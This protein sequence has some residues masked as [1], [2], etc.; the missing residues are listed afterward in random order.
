MTA[1]GTALRTARQLGPASLL[2][3]SLYQI[4]L[5]S[6]WIRRQTPRGRWQDLPAPRQPVPPRLIWSADPPAQA[7]WQE[8]AQAEAI[9]RAD[10]IL[11][12]R[13]R[14]FGLTA[15]ELGF[16][17]D[18]AAFVPL[19]GADS[20]ERVA[21]G[22]HW[23]EY[24]LDQLGA[25]AKLLWEPARFGW[26]WD[27]ARAY[28][29]RPD[30]RFAQ[31][32]WDLFDSWCQANQPNTGP[33]WIS[34]Q[35]AAF[36][37]LALAYAR[38]AFAGWLTPDRLG[39]I[40]RVMAGHASRI[41]PTLAYARAQANN[42]LLTEAAAMETAGWLLPWHRRAA[43][44]RRQGRRWFVAG[45][46]DQVFDDGGYI[47]HSTNYQRLA[48]ELGLWLAQL[49]ASQGAPLPDA[50]LIALRR[51]TRLLGRLADPD[52]GQIPNFGP[53]DGAQLLA[54]SSCGFEDYRPAL[55]AAA[56]ILGGLPR[57]PAGPWDEQAH[58]LAG[59][60]A[61][62]SDSPADY[63]GQRSFPLAGLYLLE[64]GAG[65]A[66][67]RAAR[68][69]GRPGH[70]D[71]LQLD[72]WHGGRNLLVDGGTYLYAGGPPWDNALAG[73]AAHNGPMVGGQEP[74]RRAGRFLWLPRGHARLQMKRQSPDDRLEVVTAEHTGYGWLGVR[75]RRTVLRVG[76]SLWLVI[77]DLHGAGQHG[78]TL[79]W[80]LP[81]GE[82][83]LD[84][85]LHWAEGDDRVRLWM[86]APAGAQ[87]LYVAGERVGGEALAWE[88]PVWGWQAPNYGRLA[89][90]THFVY[91]G[92]VTLPAQLRSWWAIGGQTWQETLID[93]QPGPA[94]LPQLTTVAAAE[95]LL[96]L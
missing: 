87:A 32:F 71:Q 61:P 69:H 26:A 86:E 90:A 38:Q 77:D 67:L 31:G 78:V 59:S 52:S 3:Y 10:H 84:N 43:D 37:L 70:S 1:V 46:A 62:Q 72:L 40:E 39:Q 65:R 53:N 44:W 81:P 14:L 66:V 36:R 9:Q 35:E 89:P 29:W 21:L 73:A 41:P 76:G 95:S 25:D 74:M 96:E 7:T 92:Q 13:F 45:L 47:Q 50:S 23:T 85:E 42:H 55:Q 88:S 2:H 27:L 17:P 4:G 12:G 94:Q 34:A 54:L 20:V 83:T 19:A 15:I 22:S 30:P 49:G 51:M 48:L 60:V 75:Q 64:D 57:L 82:C 33:H 11:N 91:Q 93:W 5:R 79:A 56:A 63:G 18:W 28:L 8:R 68:F 24:D 80:R 16:P 6:G 58:W